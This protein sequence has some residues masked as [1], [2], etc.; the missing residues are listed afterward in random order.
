MKYLTV[1]A[2]IISI[3]CVSCLSD[4]EKDLRSIVNHPVNIDISDTVWHRDTAL[5]F[6]DFRRKYKYLSVVY[7]LNGCRPCY[8]EFINWH[9]KM[10]SFT[11]SKD[12]TVL[13][14][15]NGDNYKDLMSKVDE[16]DQVD[17]KYYILMDP[18]SKFV[19]KNL[20]IPKWIRDGSV[21]ID[22]EN[23]IKM[24]GKPWVNSSMIELFNRVC[25]N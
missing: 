1:T 7:L 10:E 9:K 19:G 5:S 6:V 15:I 11:T 18:H 22:K 25:V 23:K 16:I 3:I 12:Y 20:N 17:K 8:Q 24:V 2:V 14:I 4:K 13:F 21:L